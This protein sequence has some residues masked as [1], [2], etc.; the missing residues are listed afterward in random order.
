MAKLKTV[1]EVLQVVPVLDQA[2]M[3]DLI[4]CLLDEFQS[5]FDLEDYEG[6]LGDLEG[7]MQD[8]IVDLPDEEDEDEDEN[9]E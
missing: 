4:G 6:L 3:V 5:N 9:D 7:M 2:Q 1:A 8:R